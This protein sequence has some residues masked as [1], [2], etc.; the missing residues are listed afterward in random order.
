[1][2]TGAFNTLGTKGNFWFIRRITVDISRYVCVVHF[3]QNIVNS[4]GG[5][6]HGTCTTTTTSIMLA[7]C[8][9]LL[10]LFLSKVSSYPFEGYRCCDEILYLYILCIRNKQKGLESNSILFCFALFRSLLCLVSSFF[11]FGLI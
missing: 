6:G 4:H 5:G 7:C 10:T 2:A 9:V 11:S 3:N 1:M 8:S